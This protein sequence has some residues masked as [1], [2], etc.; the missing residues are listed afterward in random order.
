MT[1]YMEILDKNGAMC[2]AYLYF[3]GEGESFRI[4]FDPKNVSSIKSC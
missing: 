4:R 2:R 3:N 1:G